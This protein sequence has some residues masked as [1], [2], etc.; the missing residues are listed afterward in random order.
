MSHFD[1]AHPLIRNVGFAT[2]FAIVLYIFGRTL[3]KDR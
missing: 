1:L 3:N 2:L